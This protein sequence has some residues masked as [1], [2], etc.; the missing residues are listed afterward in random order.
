MTARAGSVEPPQGSLEEPPPGLTPLPPLG[1]SL[2]DPASAGERYP[3]DFGITDQ[4]S[5]SH[6]SPLPGKGLTDHGAQRPAHETDQTGLGSPPADPAEQQEVGGFEIEATMR[7]EAPSGSDLF[8]VDTEEG[9]DAA[10]RDPDPEAGWGNI[11]IDEQSSPDSGDDDFELADSTGYAPPPPVPREKPLDETLSDHGN[12]PTRETS[13]VPAYQ[14]ETRTSSGGKK[15]LVIL[16]LLGLLG[17]GGYFAYPM[18]MKLVQS[19]SQQMEG[20]LTP[21]KV[22]V[23]ALNRTDGKIIYSVRG[24]VRNES[25]S[26]VGMVQVEAQFRNDSGEVLSK[27][28]AYCGNLFE[29]GALLN[30]DLGKVRSDLQNELGQSLS[31][32][33]IT[34]GMEV[35]F[36]VV[37]ENPPSGISKVTVTIISFKE[38]A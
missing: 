11:S 28:A 2:E 7:E 6:L 34:P 29:E 26:N 5:G 25:A 4:T 30:L 23:K 38:T 36:L 35:P 33:S 31:N 1:E 22:Q 16:L 18:V 37:L 32:A 13:R 9:P 24:V 17:G 12:A 21:A 20:T 27:A 15:A 10:L 3:S 14:P 19:R 8:G